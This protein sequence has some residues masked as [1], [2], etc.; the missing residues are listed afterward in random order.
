MVSFEEVISTGRSGSFFLRS[1]DGK[2]LIKTLPAEEHQFLR[3]NLKEYHRHIRHYPSTLICRFLGLHR[4]KNTKA[5]SQ[6]IYFVVMANLFDN[7]SIDIHE[8]Y[9]LKGSTVNRFVGEKLEIF[10]PAVAMKDLDF[11]RRIRIGPYMKALLL[12]Q[13]EIDSLVRS[14]SRVFAPLALTPFS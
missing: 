6:D 2:Y 4:L 12:E 3:R 7:T 10:N 11:H 9:D 5:A 8:Q 14:L 1:P 13:A